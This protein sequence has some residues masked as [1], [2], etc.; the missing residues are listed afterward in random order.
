MGI[1][2][3]PEGVITAA[4]IKCIGGQSLG[5]LWPRSDEERSAA[6]DAGY[7]LDEILDVD[8]LVSGQDVFFAATGVTDGD[9]LRCA[10]RVDPR[11]HR[12]ARNAHLAWTVRQ[13]G[14]RRPRE[15]GGR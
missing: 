3:T 14:P 2:G 11:D 6:V 15:A 12:V 4:A 5:R 7:D 1:G 9:V 8:R 10:L 13:S